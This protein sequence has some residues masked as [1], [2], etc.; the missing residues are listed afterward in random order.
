MKLQD[1]QTKTMCYSINGHKCNPI[2]NRTLHQKVFFSS[3]CI[4]VSLLVV[5]FFPRGNCAKIIRW[6]HATVN[7][8][9]SVPAKKID[10]KWSEI[11]WKEAL[12]CPPRRPLSWAIISLQTAMSCSTFGRRIWSHYTKIKKKNNNNNNNSNTKFKCNSGNVT[13][14]MARRINVKQEM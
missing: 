5:S 11:S 14:S 6:Y 2:Y 8:M 13:Y 4:Q 9:L 10:R 12:Q 3:S 1:F 7:S